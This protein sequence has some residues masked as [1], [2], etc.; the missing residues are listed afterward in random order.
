MINSRDKGKRGEL[1]VAE[2]LRDNGFPN[3]R[4][5]QQYK[6]GVESPDVVGMDGIHLEVKRRE[7]TEVWGWLEQAEADAGD[8]IPVVVH[9]KNGKKWIAIL[10]FTWFIEIVK[11]W[12]AWK[13][14]NGS[15]K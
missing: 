10:P 12:L 6:G 2:I 8:E 1:E 15:T 3:A 9:R 11:G 13:T 14:S 5:G 7:A 4:R